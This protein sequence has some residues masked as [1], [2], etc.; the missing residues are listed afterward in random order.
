MCGLLFPLFI[1]NKCYLAINTLMTGKALKECCFRWRCWSPA[2]R[3]NTTYGV[4]ADAG[5]A[6]ASLECCELLLSPLGWLPDLLQALWAL[7]D[8]LLNTVELSAAHSGR[9]LLSSINFVN[10]ECTGDKRCQR[11]TI[12]SE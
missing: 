8:A 6:V 1:L 2:S 4:P 5:V 10:L 3:R 11:E 9:W 7:V 12:F